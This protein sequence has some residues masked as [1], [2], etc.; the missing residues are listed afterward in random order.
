MYVYIYLNF[1]YIFKK[2]L[3]SLVPWL[4]KYKFITIANS[5]NQYK[6]KYVITKHF[7]KW[8]AKK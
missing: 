2:M 5:N 7:H 3:K 4:C 1:I 8:E 6:G